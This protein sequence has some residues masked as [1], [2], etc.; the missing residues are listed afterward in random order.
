MWVKC[1][2]FPILNCCRN[3]AKRRLWL[4]IP[5]NWESFSV[6]DFGR[7]LL[8]NIWRKTIPNQFPPYSRFVVFMFSPPSSQNHQ[9]KC[10]C[11]SSFCHFKILFANWDI[12]LCIKLDLSWPHGIKWRYEM[13]KY[14]LQRSN[15]KADQDTELYKKRAPPKRRN[16][17]R[18]LD[19]PIAPMHQ[20]CAQLQQ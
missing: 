10:S 6:S 8:Q 7:H 17:G 3:F 2:K 13:E 4:V 16:Q 20:N 1:K 5:H 12:K 9:S 11:L 15:E 18:S 14:L 19:A